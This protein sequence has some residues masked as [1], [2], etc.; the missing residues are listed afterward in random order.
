M[1]SLSRA[2]SRLLTAVLAARCVLAAAPAVSTQSIQAEPAL[3][4]LSPKASDFVSGQTL[5]S[6][7]IRPDTQPVVDVRFTV[8][9]VPA[10]TATARPYRCLFDAGPGVS[11]RAVR[12]V[13]TLPGGERLVATVATRGLT[14][15]DEVSVDAIAVSVRVTDRNGN[16][17]SGLTREDFLLIEDGERQVIAG[18]A[19][20]DAGAEVVVALDVSR[21]MEP[22]IAGLR[23]ATRLFLETLRPQEVVTLGAFS[24]ALTVVAPSSA[25]LA[26]RIAR[27]DDL[28]SG[29]NTALY[30]AMAG[31]AAHF[32][33]A[34]QR[35]VVVF[36]DGRDIVSR[37]SL[38]GV[39]TAL[40]SADVGLY[41][42]GQ[43]EAAADGDLR[44][45]LSRLARETGGEAYFSRQPE[46]LRRHFA[47]IA[48]D[49]A[50]RYLLTYTP[51]RPLGDGGWRRLEVRLADPRSSHVV[52]A[53]EGYLAVRRGPAPDR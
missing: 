37:A 39:R 36:T 23:A 35:A 25:T 32:R 17:V 48:D 42:I 13:A 3:V 46:A 20:E 44:D 38:G 43:G 49:I 4:I 12:A 14:V 41:V 18:F 50:H 22:A 30:D 28:R 5:L 52:R 51:A 1:E 6:A 31:A 40:Q 11:A 27:L 26:E 9:G 21:S 10:C 8:N 53:R 45:R 34:G 2:T 24:T 7:A 29:G 15:N 19:A 47:E 16:F 33:E